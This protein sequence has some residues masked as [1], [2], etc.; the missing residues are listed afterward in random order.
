MLQKTNPVISIVVP[1]YDDEQYIE[2]CLTSLIRQTYNDIEIIC[3][4]DCST[5]MSSIILQKF[6]TEDPRVKV[7]RFDEN[8]SASYAR[9]VGVLKATGKYI[10]FVD[11]DDYL[12]ETACEVLFPIAEESNVDIFHFGAKIINCGN[13]PQQA[14]DNKCRY[15]APYEELIRESNL[16]RAHAIERKISVHL[17]GKL[18]N[19]A[20]CKKAFSH[21]E[22]GHFPKANDLYAMFIIAYFAS[23]YMGKDYG[24]YRYCMGRG[25]EGHNYMGLERFE[26]FCN[27]EIVIS[28]IKRF[29]SAKGALNKCKAVL[30]A[31]QQSMM[32]HILRQLD[33]VLD[34]AFYLN[35][36]NLM[37]KYFGDEVYKYRKYPA[38]SIVV[39]VY[40]DEPYLEQCIT[41]L[42][43][44]TFRNIEIICVDDCS[45]D[46]SYDMLLDFANKDSR[47]KIIRFD[48]NSSQ[49]QA[50]KKGVE[51]AQGEYIMFVDADDYIDTITCRV[52]YGMAK[53]SDADIIHFG[54]NVINCSGLPQSEIDSI[55]KYL[56]PYNGTIKQDNLLRVCAV[57][58][59]ICR[60]LCGKLY[61]ADICKKA[62]SEIEDGYFSQEEDVYASY[63][64][65]FYS[66]T[67]KGEN[68]KLYNNCRGRG[69]SGHSQ[70]DLNQFENY[71]TNVNIVAPLERFLTSNGVIEL[72]QDIID[73]RNKAGL[74]SNWHFWENSLATD[75]KP[76]GFD[77]LI[78]YRGK[79]III[80]ELEKRYREN[81]VEASKS[82]KGAKSLERRCKSIKTVATYC[83]RIYN[84]GIERVNANLILMWKN[85]GYDVILL[86][87]EEVS[88]KE[89]YF[90]DD[91][92]RIILPA[93]RKDR[94][95]MLVSTINKYS[96]D[97]LIYHPYW[98]VNAF[99][100]VLA[101]KS[102]GCAA[103][104]YIHN[105]FA[106][107][108]ILDPIYFAESHHVYN[109]F[110]ALMTLSEVDSAYWQNI[111]RN[112]IKTYNP[113]TFELHETKPSTLNEMSVLWVG[114]FASIKNPQHALL[115]IENVLE[116]VPNV[117]LH[118]VGDGEP[119]YTSLEN[120][121]KEKGLEHAV[122]LHGFH[123]EVGEFYENASVFLLT[124]DYEGFCLTLYESKSYGVPCIA[125][126]MPYLDSFR[127]GRGIIAVPHGDIQAAAR[128]VVN[129][130]LD[131]EHRCKLGAE[132][133]ASVEDYAKK[134]DI[135]AVWRNTFDNLLEPPKPCEVK[136]DT[137]NILIRTI[138]SSSE[139]LRINLMQQRMEMTVKT[140]QKEL[141]WI[142]KE[143]NEFKREIDLIRMS[144]TYKIGR[145][146]TYIPRK[147]REFRNQKRG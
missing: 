22:D 3:V 144:W 78:K 89:Y 73:I 65:A 124:S 131:D 92:V 71:C 39:P 67:Y 41:S 94:H 84:G 142:R 9:K 104:L 33:N 62:F 143:R 129:L 24:F 17:W 140:G 7:I 91:I 138:Q 45:T 86:T 4:D 72:Y 132:A 60:N 26:L 44:Q 135:E 43:R 27:Q 90:P 42:T 46:G 103:I 61:K 105:I 70:I 28:A 125:Y 110:D 15:E 121:I 38:I 95:A 107:Q 139:L 36:F 40:N 19:A 11:G 6:A 37:V 47:I 5:D 53:N 63:V 118:I 34:P 145:F 128:E 88:D 56:T 119:I 68:H 54:A 8:K 123:K 82:I 115:I 114:R 29:L 25:N 122:V 133:R 100:D 52:V 97:A 136:N 108:L 18:F 85:M 66:Q 147:L 48:K 96:V 75:D 58:K 80:Q 49:S 106:K 81:I 50:R 113:L 51:I 101:I 35:G 30:D 112:T 55:A 14:I 83:H 117:K 69:E 64:I 93:E 99:W 130:L 74:D 111:N 31:R 1:V 23:T 126:D 137:N 109:H 2:Q 21:I 10:M 87:D 16:L 59:K 77:I 12:A 13:L 120:E 134:I 141:E 79:D 102:C 116:Y 98:S 146:C 76:A 20:T 57:E 32:N 127:D